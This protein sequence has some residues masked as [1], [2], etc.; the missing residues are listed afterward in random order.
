MCNLYNEIQQCGD[1]AINDIK[2]LLHIAMPYTSNELGIAHRTF[3][4]EVEYSIRDASLPILYY[5]CLTTSK[6]QFSKTYNMQLRFVCLEKTLK[7][8]IENSML[9]KRK[10]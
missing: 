10:K 6:L 3:I 8:M 4:S 2:L 5:I 9:I 1:D 7:L